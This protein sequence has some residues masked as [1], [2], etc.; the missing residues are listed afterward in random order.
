MKIGD[1]VFRRDMPMLKFRIT[2]ENEHFPDMWNVEP[3][4]FYKGLFAPLDEE[5]NRKA[6]YGRTPRRKKTD[7]QMISKN[8]DRWI[9][10]E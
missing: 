9:V 3:I 8:D 1:I 4:R 5:E 2:G 6:G 10:I 7:K